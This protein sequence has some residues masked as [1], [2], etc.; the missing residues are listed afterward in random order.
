[1][2]LAVKKDTQISYQMSVIIYQ[3]TLH[4][5]SADLNVLKNNSFQEIC[6]GSEGK[7]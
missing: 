7:E 1:M 5:I 4:P 6:E 3:S 2:L